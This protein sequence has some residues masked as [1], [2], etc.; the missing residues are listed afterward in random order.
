M[1][2]DV[3]AGLIGIAP[4]SEALLEFAKKHE[5][6]WVDVTLDLEVP[7][8]EKLYANLLER[9]S[10]S[11]SGRF[12]FTSDTNLLPNVS[13]DTIIKY[14][15]HE[16]DEYHPWFGCVFTNNLND[17]T[18]YTWVDKEGDIRI[19]YVAEKVLKVD[20]TEQLRKWISSEN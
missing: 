8:Q 20:P 10:N 18:F 14:D 19:T 11:D 4:T 16:G 7:D 2:A 6:G 17:T 12:I 9:S 5:L 15:K 1:D 3:W 13:I